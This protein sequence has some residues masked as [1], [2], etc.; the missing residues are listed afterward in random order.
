MKQPLCLRTLITTVF[1]VLCCVP[2]AT[3]QETSC[4]DLVDPQ[5][6]RLIENEQ[7]TELI[8]KMVTDWK[9][10]DSPRIIRFGGN[11]TKSGLLQ[12]V[13]CIT[14]NFGFSSGAESRLRSR[15]DRLRFQPAINNSQPQR[16]F[17]TFTLFASKTA[18]GLRTFLLLNH[19]RS[20]DEFGATYSA[21]QRIWDNR[22]MWSG[23]RAGGTVYIEVQADIDEHGRASNAKVMDENSRTTGI[24]GAIAG[25]LENACFIPGFHDGEPKE[26][27]YSETFTNQ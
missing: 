19:L 10:E 11:V 21:P 18:S 22:A 3:A 9:T 16:V 7:T 2:L 25:R 8:G 24:D 23:R 26:M 14:T 6:T 13:C 4:P 12:D 17:V 1:S 5:P 20:L 27:V 15:L